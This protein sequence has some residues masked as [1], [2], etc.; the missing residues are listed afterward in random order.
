MV[1]EGKENFYDDYGC[2]VAVP[3]VGSVGCATATLS[4]AGAAVAVLIAIIEV[5]ASAGAGAEA[6]VL[7]AVAA[8]V[9]AG[10]VAFLG[11]GCMIAPCGQMVRSSADHLLPRIVVLE[12]T[13]VRALVM[14]G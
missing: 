10:T 2:G 11:V 12:L 5:V 13:L 4:S 6:A 8:A 3:V 9:G 1:Y 14:E 7:G